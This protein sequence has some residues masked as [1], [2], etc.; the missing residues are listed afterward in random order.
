MKTMNAIAED[1]VKE[2]YKKMKI[3]YQQKFQNITQLEQEC[4]GNQYD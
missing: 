3:Q 1:K 2:T 4:L